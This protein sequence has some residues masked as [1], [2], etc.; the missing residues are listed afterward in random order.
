MSE[1]MN[2]NEVNWP[3]EKGGTSLFVVLVKRTGTDSQNFQEIACG[4]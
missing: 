1:Q 3:L 2:E 4:P